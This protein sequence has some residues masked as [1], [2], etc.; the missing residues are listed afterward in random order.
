M[1][2]SASSGLRRAIV[3]V[4]KV[5]FPEEELPVVCGIGGVLAEDVLLHLN[6]ARLTH[7]GGM[8]VRRS[9][10]VI[11]VQR[12]A[13]LVLMS[14]AVTMGVVVR[15]VVKRVPFEPALALTTTAYR[16]H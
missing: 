9:L 3:S 14:M 7:A 5:V 4:S 16:A 1:T 15:G 8:R 6:H 12:V 2:A 13:V 10:T 11:V